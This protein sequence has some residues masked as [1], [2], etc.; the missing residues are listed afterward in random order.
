MLGEFDSEIKT[1]SPRLFK[2]IPI[3]GIKALSVWGL[4]YTGRNKDPLSHNNFEVINRTLLSNFKR[5]RTVLIF[6][7][8]LVFHPVVLRF[9]NW[10]VSRN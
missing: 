9:K 6:L 5:D 2:P 3:D 7:N 4:Q 8:R 10:I 1:S